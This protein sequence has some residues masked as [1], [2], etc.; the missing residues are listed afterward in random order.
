MPSRNTDSGMNSLHG[1]DAGELSPLEGDELC[2]EGAKNDRSIASQHFEV[3]AW[4]P[5]GTNLHGC[6]V[7]TTLISNTKGRCA[8][9]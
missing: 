9:F 2:E 5:T 4:M 1:G 6:I 8:A 3:E 7:K